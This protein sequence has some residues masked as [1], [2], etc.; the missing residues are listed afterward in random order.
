[1]KFTK[2]QY[3]ILKWTARIY[4][5]VILIIG[6]TFYFGY[7]NPLPFT[8][9]NYSL[10]DNI[11]LSVFPLIFIGLGLGWKFEKA[12]GFLIVFSIMLGFILGSVVKK[13]F[14]M[15]NLPMPMIISLA[16][17]FIYILSGYLKIKN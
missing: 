12:A 11:W 9:R 15:V 17:G 16:A 2:P 7:G 8:N 4:A 3:T 1:M 10:W 6:L 5:A 13:D 14:S